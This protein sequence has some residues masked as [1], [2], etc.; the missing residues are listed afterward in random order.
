VEKLLNSLRRDNPPMLTL[1][2]LNIM[3]TFKVTKQN[4]RNFIKL[5]NHLLFMRESIKTG[6]GFGLT[7]GVITTLGLLVGLDA[8]TGSKIAVIGGILTIAIADSFSDAIGIHNSEES[9]K[10]NGHRAIWEATIST[11]FAKFLIAVTFVIPFLLFDISNAVIAS[12]IWGALLLT[13][14]TYR[15]ARKRKENTFKFIF[16]HLIVAAVVVIIAY[17]AGKGIKVWFG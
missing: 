4:T 7:S 11:F 3:P 16:S 2:F 6:L 15:L 14:F 17:F 5:F 12:I 8:S 10:R 1:R 13:I 9:K